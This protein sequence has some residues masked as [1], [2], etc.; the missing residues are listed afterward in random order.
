MEDLARDGRAT[1]EPSQSVLRRAVAASAVGNA[2]EWFDYGIYACGVVYTS[3]A[4]ARR[5]GR[6]AAG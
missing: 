2:T 3:R 6:A 5:P 4:G 1:A